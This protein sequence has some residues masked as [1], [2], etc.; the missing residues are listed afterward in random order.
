MPR[1]AKRASTVLSAALHIEGSR[2]PPSN[3]TRVWMGSGRLR[4]PPGR[5]LAVVAAAAFGLAIQAC[6]GGDAVTT[7]PLETAPP[8][9]SEEA[10]SEADATFAG[11]I[12]VAETFMETYDGYDA[13]RARALLADDVQIF[14]PAF[15]DLPEME[16]I[17]KLDS[18]VELNRVVG[19]R[20][21][22]Y[23]CD[24]Q[25]RPDEVE[26]DTP[27]RVRCTYTMD[28]RLQQI[29]GYPPIDGGAFSFLV[30]DGVITRFDDRFPFL[31]FDSNV[32][33][34]F[35]EWLDAEHPAAVESLFIG[36]APQ[37]YPRL[38]PEALDLLSFYLDEYEEWVNSSQE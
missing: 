28:S 12:A 23:V 5:L 16:A 38:S 30:I 21:S 13:E 24:L 22:P 25:F 36:T 3:W 10:D 6:A 20:F 4:R 18:V 31:E 26:P 17:E 7:T 32:G 8:P 2:I 9:A 1:L 11:A 29:V 19:F 34:G 14:S 35:I 15:R 37:R 27:L 33:A